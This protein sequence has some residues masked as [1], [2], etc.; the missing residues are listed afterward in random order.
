[1]ATRRKRTGRKRSGS[2]WTKKR[3]G[4]AWTKKRTGSAWTKKR[5]TRRRKKR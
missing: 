4:S 1:M 5:T 2:A 3:T